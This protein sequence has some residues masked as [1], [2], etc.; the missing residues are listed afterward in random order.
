MRHGMYGK[1]GYVNDYIRIHLSSFSLIPTACG[2]ERA[3]KIESMAAG[4]INK[5]KHQLLI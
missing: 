5:H 1:Q 3:K 2:L 4:L